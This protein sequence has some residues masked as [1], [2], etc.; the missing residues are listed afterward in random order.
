MSP[1]GTGFI[2]RVTLHGPFRVFDDL[3]RDITPNGMKERGLFALLLLS[4][5]QRC[6]RAWM[7]DKLWSDRSPE[8]SSTSFRQAL[9]KLRKSLG[10][11]GHRLHSDRSALWI[12]PPLPLD[13]M[14]NPALGELLQDI[15]IA[16]PEFTAWLRLK[17]SQ[18]SPGNEPHPQRP[19][20]RIR[21]INRSVS[22]RSDFGL[23][24][25]S[26]RFASRLGAMADL[27]VIEADIDDIRRDAAQP[28]VQIELECLDDAEM[29]FFLLR[30]IS[31]PNRR[32]AWSGRL[33]VRANMS[34]F[35]VSPDVT[36]AVNQTVQAAAEAVTKVTDLTPMAAIHK[37]IRRRN[38]FDR[39]SLAKADA[40]LC[41]ALDSPF[42]ALALAWRSMVRLDEVMEFRET[43]PLRQSEA[44]D[45][46]VEAAK[47]APD[48]S[49]VLAM[50]SEVT[51]FLTGDIDMASYYANRAIDLDDQEPEALAAV[52]RTLSFDGKDAQAHRFAL[53]AQHHAQGSLY[54]SEWDMMA[55]IA[56]IRIGD[57][58]GAYDMIL[59][60]HRKM[61]F[62]R[63][64]LRYLT[65]LSILDERP[66][67]A[68]RYAERLRRLEP[69]FNVDLLRG[70]YPPLSFS[71]DR[72]LMAEVRHKL[73]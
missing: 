52:G 6:T 31:P 40:L 30:V 70:S 33:S 65:V 10:P 45:F 67:D 51:L 1:E 26:Q 41:S 8:Q 72:N 35:W 3:G 66:A 54:S 36:R 5:G 27:D 68:S 18:V 56:K 17:R 39:T 59:A 53:A 32:I 48:N 24:A 60:C 2:L 22:A 47:L 9:S 58:A 21:R 34:E 19:F 63:H 15:D 64:A 46:A 4:P 11:L 7:Q 44:L 20:A 23:R 25:L 42:R 62:G 38:E 16:D 61:P 73:A 13:E 37:A 14:Q 50:S 55:G 28:A 29:S 71:R 12:D 69:D 49:A 43:D 57:M